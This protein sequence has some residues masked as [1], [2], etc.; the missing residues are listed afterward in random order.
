MPL[1][2]EE[3]LRRK[4]EKRQKK[5]AETHKFVN[6][7]EYKYCSYGNHWLEINYENFYY[8]EKSYDGLHTYCKK[9][10]SKKAYKWGK[11]NRERKLVSYRKDSARPERRQKQ[12]EGMK[13]YREEG[14]AKEWQQNNKEK[15]REYN[16]N[17]QMHKK[18][19]ITK[20]EWENCKNYFNYRCAY[21]GL[22]V[23]K[24]FKMRN[25]ELK[26]TDLHKEHVDHEGSNDLSNCV[27]SC[28]SCNSSKYYYS[29]E[30]WYVS[31][32]DFFSEERL[33]KIHKWLT[34]DYLKYKE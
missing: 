32:K 7:I 21:C 5:I 34:E 12:K 26:Q 9:C 2:E 8:I 27:P 24:H 13:K 15:I 33:S 17:R 1:T 20:E 16:K 29:L 23:E 30:N 11:D 6:G 4:E 22:A 10:T 14:R 31:T 19:E 28:H 25:S 3:K 18:H